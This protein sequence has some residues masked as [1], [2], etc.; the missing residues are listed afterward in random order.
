MAWHLAAL[1]DSASTGRSLAQRNLWLVQ[2]LGWVRA[3]ESDGPDPGPV[4]RLRQLCQMLEQHDSHRQPVAELLSAF[5]R[6]A[7]AVSLLAD[8]G[9][10]PRS[11]FAAELA[12]RLRIKLLPGTPD[13]ANLAALFPLLFEPGDEVWLSQ[14]DT[15]TR[16][17]LEAL[18]PVGQ[19]PWRDSILDAI[20]Y[21]CSAIR[22]AGFS[23]ALRL[24]MSR[25]AQVHEPFR[26]LARAAETLR[27]ALAQGQDPQVA[28]AVSYLRALLAECR[29]AAH[30]VLDHLEEFGVS[31]HI[32]FDVDQLRLR[33][34]RV[35][36][37]LDHLMAPPSQAAAE[38]HRL[39]LALVA[40]LRQTRS[41]R[42]L[43]LEQSRLL[44]RQVAERNAETGEHY[45]TRT[46]D[47]YRQMLRAAAGGGV[48]IAGTTFAKFAIA[49]LGLSAFW[50]GFWAGANY[51]ASFVIVMLLHWTVATKQPAMTAPAM[52]AKLSALGPRASSDTA[53]VEA[54]VDEVTHLIRSQVAGMVGNVALC[55]PLVLAVQALAMG[56]FGATPIGPDEARY[57]LQ[58]VTLLG[59]TALYAAFT[60]ILLFASS[61]LA[62]WV[63]NWFVFNRL[64][65]ALEWNPRLRDRLGPERA[66]RWARWWRAHISGM[67]A[68]VSLGLMLGLVPVLLHFFGVPLDVRHVTLSAGQ[69]AA[70]LGALG[71]AALSEPGFWWVLA[72]I[73]V[74]GVLNVGISFAL[75]FRVA[76]RARSVQVAERSAIYRAIGQRVRR[77]P[78][79]FL[80]PPA[81][82][83][84]VGTSAPEADAAHG[85]THGPPHEPPRE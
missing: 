17:R 30:S 61:L 64:D 24:R 42:A 29:Q 77:S 82:C 50:S 45:I 21:L 44:S 26:Q 9:F 62:G 67:A 34:E 20:T 32:V 39:L 38:A 68:N 15:P 79:S 33:T 16:Q 51:A 40:T 5:L 12:R 55:F 60:G 46:R 70:A 59:P 10:A 18:W 73:P 63:E 28:Q 83:L 13:T 23:E 84:V 53:A 52:A 11:S 35:E 69:A 56:L 8:Y 58:S 78:L 72:A 66:A 1:L 43:L 81:P 41:V 71:T 14:L 75:A 54:F 76:L 27:E 47:E 48:V 65:S 37:L 6:D 31:L 25:E 80:R 4:L 57:V 3:G 74:I 85:S 19:N 36:L 49:A 22:A 2:L 7:D